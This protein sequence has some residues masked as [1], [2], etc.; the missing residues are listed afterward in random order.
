LVLQV[1][2]REVNG[3]GVLSGVGGEVWYA[4]V[5][6]ATW[7]LENPFVVRGLDVLELGSGLGLCGIVAGYLA[8]SVVLTG[9]DFALEL[10]ENLKHNAARNRMPLL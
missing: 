5:L 3:N 9:M 6:L 7:I 4:A 8:E 1:V 2:L 10:L